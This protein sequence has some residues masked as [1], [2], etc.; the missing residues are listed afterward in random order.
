MSVVDEAVCGVDALDNWMEDSIGLAAESND[1]D[2]LLRLTRNRALLHMVCGC[3]LSMREVATLTV[4]E[5]H[6]HAERTPVRQSAFAS[7]RTA[8]AYVGGRNPVSSLQL[9]LAVS[10]ISRGL[11]FRRINRGKLS[12]R[13]LPVSYLDTLIAGILRSADLADEFDAVDFAFDRP[14]RNQCI[15]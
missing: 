13:P 9:W 14:Q 10:G 15:S 3:R 5:I 8:P 6:R 12:R 2:A 11:V 7:S 1:L 4:E